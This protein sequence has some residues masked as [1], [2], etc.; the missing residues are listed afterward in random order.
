MSRLSAA[1]TSLNTQCLQNSAESG[2]TECLNTRVPSAYPAVCGIQREAD[3]KISVRPV[4]AQGHKR[5]I[6]AD[7]LS[8]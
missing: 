3:N 8:T 4:V 7:L 6:V 2:G 1:L 5:A